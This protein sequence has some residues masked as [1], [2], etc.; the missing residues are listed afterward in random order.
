MLQLF[1][2]KI[3]DQGIPSAP[4][5]SQAELWCAFGVDEDID[6]PPAS[7][8]N[9]AGRSTQRRNRKRR[10]LSDEESGQPA[11]ASG[12]DPSTAPRDSAAAAPE[13]TAGLPSFSDADDQVKSAQPSVLAA[14]RDKLGG[15]AGVQGGRH[16][17]G[18]VVA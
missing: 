7:P 16:D 18:R 3:V 8:D 10:I 9:P 12:G 15:E 6:V 1:P 14:D 13:R 17:A 4:L 2:T 11:P 5:Q